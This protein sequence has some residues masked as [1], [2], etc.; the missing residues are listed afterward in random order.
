MAVSIDLID[1]KPESSLVLPPSMGCHEH[2]LALLTQLLFPVFW[3]LYPDDFPPFH[4]RV[5]VGA[6]P[7]PLLPGSTCS[8]PSQSEPA[9]LSHQDRLRCKN[10]ERRRK[11]HLCASRYFK[12]LSFITSFNPYKNKTL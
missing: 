7:T 8:R 4:L 3:Q 6:E 5:R 10:H 12:N 2:L 9:H 11:H 1:L